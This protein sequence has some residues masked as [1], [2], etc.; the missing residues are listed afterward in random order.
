MVGPM[1]FSR[2]RISVFAQANIMQRKHAH[3]CGDRHR[4][5]MSKCS[6]AGCSYPKLPLLLH[7]V[8]FSPNRE[9]PLI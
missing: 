7:H 5:S 1:I 9:T 8:V 6:L 3:C 2:V 4:G